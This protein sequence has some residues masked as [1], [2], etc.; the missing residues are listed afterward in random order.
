MIRLKNLLKEESGNTIRLKNLLKEAL[1]GLDYVQSI[2]SDEPFDTSQPL[3]HLAL[4][5]NL[6]NI[7]REGLKPTMPKAG[8]HGGKVKGEAFAGVWLSSMDDPGAMVD[9]HMLPRK[10]EYQGIVLQIDASKLDPK[11]FSLGIEIPPGLYTKAQNGEKISRNEYYQ[12]SDEIVYLGKIPP[13]AITPN[14]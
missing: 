4:E 1:T 12:Q 9:I 8:M 11:L 7:M 13:N 6:D 3:Y 14:N 5:S 10:Y 2:Q